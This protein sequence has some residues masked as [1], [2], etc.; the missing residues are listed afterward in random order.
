MN[1]A[2]MML[3]TKTVR[4]MMTKKDYVEFQRRWCESGLRLMEF[5]RREGV[6]H[7]TY[8]GWRKKFPEVTTDV[9]PSNVLVPVVLK[10]REVAVSP[11]RTHE[12]LLP[13]DGRICLLFPNGVA[14]S[15]PCEKGEEAT[16]MVNAYS[17]VLPD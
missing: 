7:S 1:F 15:L 9:A 13:S 11:H 3:N 17:H 12:H 6:P 16:R 8:N 10:K 4:I 2:V 5:L 14:A